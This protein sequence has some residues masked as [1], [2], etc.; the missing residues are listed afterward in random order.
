MKAKNKSINRYLS[1]EEFISNA[2]PLPDGQ[3]KIL[4]IDLDYFND[5]NSF[6][7]S[8]L[9]SDEVIKKNLTDI[10]KYV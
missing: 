9:K 10:K 3:S 7:Y 1:I 8:D 5:S 6:T 4:D 2:K